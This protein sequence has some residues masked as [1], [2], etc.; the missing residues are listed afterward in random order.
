MLDLL[1]N[2]PILL[3]LL[4]VQADDELNVTRLKYLGVVLG[5]ETR[6]PLAV[7]RVGAW[8]AKLQELIR[9]YPS[10]VPMLNPLVETIGLQVKLLESDPTQPESIVQPL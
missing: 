5:G 3:I 4:L 6:V 10:L 9:H 1:L 2:K 8:P 7:D